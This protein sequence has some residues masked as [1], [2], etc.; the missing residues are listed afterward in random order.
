M[1]DPELWVNRPHPGPR[2]KPLPLSR[3]DREKL[4]AAI[5]PATAEKRI[6]RRAE[7]W[8][9]MADGVSIRDTGA[10]LGVDDATVWRWRKRFQQA[11][12]IETALADAPRSGRPRALSRRPMRH[13]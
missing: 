13:A 6:V 7:A 9:L 11:D 3:K 2:G 12:S 8:L 4:E 5:R 1:V 10:A